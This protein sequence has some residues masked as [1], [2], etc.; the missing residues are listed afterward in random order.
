MGV[1]EPGSTTFTPEGV[2]G[3]IPYAGVIIKYLLNNNL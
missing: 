3:Y 2:E 1:V